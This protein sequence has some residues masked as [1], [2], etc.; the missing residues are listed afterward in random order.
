MKQ[1]NHAYLIL[2]VCGILFTLLMSYRSLRTDAQ[3]ANVTL[4]FDKYLSLDWPGHVL[5]IIPVVM[6]FFTFGEAVERYPALHGYARI[7][8]AIVGGMG[9][10]IFQK[11]LSEAKTWIRKVIDEKTNELDAIK[12]EQPS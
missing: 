3:K 2:G 12:G 5:S 10:W 8:F 11:V 6:W 4:P 9:S 1:D 7:S